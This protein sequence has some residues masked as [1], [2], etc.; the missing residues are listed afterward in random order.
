MRSLTSPP[1][2]PLFINQQRQKVLNDLKFWYININWPTTKLLKICAQIINYRVLILQIFLLQNYNMQSEDLVV[3]GVKIWLSFTEFWVWFPV[4]SVC[5]FICLQSETFAHPKDKT[6]GMSRISANP[7]PTPTPFS[8]GSGPTLHCRLAMSA[9]TH[10]HPL[11]GVT[12][13]V[14]MHSSTPQPIPHTALAGTGQK[15]IHRTYLWL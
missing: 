11:M 8:N 9:I 1:F 4:T 2:I 12:E 13:S 6:L 10:D 3:S 15:D 5:K 7:P 14:P